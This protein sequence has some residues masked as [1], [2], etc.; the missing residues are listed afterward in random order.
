[1]VGK[2]RRRV[3]GAGVAVPGAYWRRRRACRGPRSLRLWPGGGRKARCGVVAVAE[4]WVGLD[5]SKPPRLFASVASPWVGGPSRRRLAEAGRRKPKP[6]LGG[7]V[8]GLPAG[9]GTVSRM[10]TNITRLPVTFM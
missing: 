2:V 9:Q 5:S 4:P 8:C 10:T 3:V 1:M 6:P 7:T